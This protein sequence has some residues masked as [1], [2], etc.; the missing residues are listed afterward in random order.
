MSLEKYHLE[1]WMTSLPLGLNCYSKKKTPPHTLVL[2]AISGQEL[3]VKAKSSHLQC[4]LFL[5]A[6]YL[7]DNSKYQKLSPALD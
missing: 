6:P 5:L 4:R 1:F 2:G 3:I 7:K